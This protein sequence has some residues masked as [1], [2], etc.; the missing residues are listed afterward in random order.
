MKWLEQ[1]PETFKAYDQVIRD[2]LVNSVIEKI[3]ENQGENPKKFFLSHR[4]VIKQNAEST[5]LR[6][7]YNASAES[8]SGYSL[9]DC[10]EKGPSLQNKLWDILIRT[11]FRPPRKPFS[12]PVSKI[13]RESP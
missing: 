2:H 8:E 6:V 9:N 5:K 1:N 4:P 13:K 3:S 12:K 10:L 7:A 11:R